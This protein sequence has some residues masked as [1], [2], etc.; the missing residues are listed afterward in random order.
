[1]V[2]TEPCEKNNTSRKENN[3]SYMYNQ[4]FVKNNKNNGKIKTSKQT[5]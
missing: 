3:N 1:M 2:T 5:I 4:K